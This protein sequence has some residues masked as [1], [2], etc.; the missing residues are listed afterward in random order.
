MSKLI[1]LTQKTVTTTTTTLATLVRP[2]VL[3]ASTNTPPSTTTI[4]PTGEAVKILCHVS[5]VGCMAIVPTPAICATTSYQ[6]ITTQPR[7]L[8]CMEE[9]QKIAS[10][11]RQ[12][13]VPGL[14]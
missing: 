4:K 10:G 8:T 14:Q 2:A 3:L 7:P 6:D 1:L 13:D 9:V 12:P 5:I 11:R